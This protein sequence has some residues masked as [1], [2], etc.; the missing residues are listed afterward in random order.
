MYKR[1]TAEAAIYGL[2]FKGMTDICLVNLAV[3]LS[4]NLLR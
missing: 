1:L 2:R 4:H 3:E